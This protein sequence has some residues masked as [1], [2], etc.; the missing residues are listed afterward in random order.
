MDQGFCYHSGVTNNHVSLKGAKR[1]RSVTEGIGSEAPAEP[2][3]AF[4][5][6]PRTPGTRRLRVQSAP[7]VA[8]C[9]VEGRSHVTLTTAELS[10]LR[11]HGPIARGSALPTIVENDDDDDDVA[12]EER[13]AKRPRTSNASPAP[14]DAAPTIASRPARKPSKTHVE[15][16]LKWSRKITSNHP[17]VNSQSTL[18]STA[19]DRTTPTKTSGGKAKAPSF[20]SR[21]VKLEEVENAGKKEALKAKLGVVKKKKSTK[22]GTQDANSPDASIHPTVSRRDR[23][24]DLALGEAGPSNDPVGRRTTRAQTRAKAEGGD[25]PRPSRK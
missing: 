5:L 1:K 2:V 7:L 11:M 3:I 6:R 23:V 25:G 17:S 22:A 19:A 14:R 20:S 9:K 13:P 10:F 8:A 21:K 24:A 16:Q 4:D 15:C 18:T 12:E